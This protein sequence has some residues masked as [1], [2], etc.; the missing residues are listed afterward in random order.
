MSVKAIPT[1]LNRLP[2]VINAIEYIRRVTG[3]PRLECQ[4]LQLLLTLYEHKE[5]I[6]MSDLANLLKVD[7]SF[8]SRNARAFGGQSKGKEL[9]YQRIDPMNPK[10]RLIQLTDA[11][12]KAIEEFANVGNGEPMPRIPRVIDPRKHDA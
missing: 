9:V 12:R 1:T 8:V 6:S 5:G 11:G 2:A 4:Q 10:V 3:R 7:P